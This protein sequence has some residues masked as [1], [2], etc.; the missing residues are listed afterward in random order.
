MGNHIFMLF[1]GNP[2]RMLWTFVGAAALFA[3]V[4]PIHFNW[5]M[6]R[7]FNVL[8]PWLKIAAFIAI[9]VG[10]VKGILHPKKGGC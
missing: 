10:V 4:D 8:W 1:F 5:A 2:R 6:A 9:A 7:A 3:F